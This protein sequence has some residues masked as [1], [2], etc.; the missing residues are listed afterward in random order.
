MQRPGESSLGTKCKVCKAEGDTERKA[1]EPH[2]G[3]ETQRGLSPA[4]Q[5]DLGLAGAIVSQDES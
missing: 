2:M 3:Q 5:T 1:W 4:G